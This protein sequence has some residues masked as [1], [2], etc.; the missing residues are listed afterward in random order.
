MMKGKIRGFGDDG[1]ENCNE[2]DFEA[3]KL[4]ERGRKKKRH[5][6]LGFMEEATFSK[7]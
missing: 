2:G 5:E 6:P 4:L 1:V 3:R 7:F